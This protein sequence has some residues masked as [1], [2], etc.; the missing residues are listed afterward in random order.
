MRILIVD[1]DAL[2]RDSLKIMLDLEEEFSEVDTA[3]NGQ[4]ALELCSKKKFDIVLMDI[5]MPIM[6]GVLATKKI[7]EQFRDMKIIILTT[8]K[9]DEYI[10]QAV[11]NGAEGYILKN[12]PVESIIE[13]IK[14]VKKGN[15]VFQKEIVES[16]TMMLKKDNQID[17]QNYDFSAREFEVLKLAGNGLSNKEI[18][19]KLFLGEGT[20]R[21]YVSTLL[22]KLILRDRTQLAI[23][24]VKNYYH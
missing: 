17:K 8:F 18:S 16:I 23:F 15:V 9:E 14:L 7:K 11:K 22:E 4:E 21:N 6:D 1:D 3:S 13:S 2:I 19:K 20:V 10:K 5:R 24:Y 12:Q